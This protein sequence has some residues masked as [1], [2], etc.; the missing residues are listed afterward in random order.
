LETFDKLVTDSRHPLI[1]VVGGS[2]VSSKLGALMNMLSVVDTFIIGGAMANTFLR[3]VGIDV[4]SSKIEG[5]L[6]SAAREIMSRAAEKGIKVYLPVDAVVSTEIAAESEASTV[7]IQEIPENCMV[8]DIGPAT[9]ILFSEALN[10][11]E[12]IIWNG[13]MGIFEADAYARGTDAVARA[14]AQSSAVTIAGGGDTDAAIHR[15]GTGGQMTYISTGG[16][17]FLALLEGKT[18]PA[19]EALMRQGSA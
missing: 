1:A 15:S 17:A 16:G 2:K 14:V 5:D 7:P 6:I 4:G 9:A 19:V 18:L 10:R 11:A 3:A 12:T 13:P 8:L